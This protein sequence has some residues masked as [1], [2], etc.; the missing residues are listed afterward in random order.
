[1]TEKPSDKPFE[2][3]YPTYDVLGKWDS[4]SFNDQTRRVVADRLSNPPARRFLEE[5][6][7]AL[8]RAVIDVIL[9]QPERD[10]DRRIPVEA[11]IDEMLFAN[12]GS[13][14]RYADAPPMREAWRRGLA[15]I[16]QEARRRHGKGFE[17]LSNDRKQALLHAIDQGDVDPQAWEGLKPQRFFR[18]VLLKESV[19]IYYAHPYA[20]NE[21][22]FGG[23]ASPRGYVRLGSDMRD[24][25]EA[26]EER[27]PQ[28]TERLSRA[29]SFRMP[30]SG[31][32]PLKAAHP[33][34]SVPANGCR[35]PSLRKT[36]RSTS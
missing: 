35:W 25:W 17:S 12:R 13:G 5:A 6:E 23:P 28:K 14:T 18:H 1:M 22:G 19:K 36:R 11:F 24:P 10:E 32:A 33:T 3:P 7:F 4:P 31:R 20:W 8:L 34:S 21:I 9:P 27:I 30:S 26:R 16:E 2:T 15:G 29:G